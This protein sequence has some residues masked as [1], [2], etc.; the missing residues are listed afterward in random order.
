LRK[1]EERSREHDDASL[2]ELLVRIGREYAPLNRIWKDA[3]LGEFNICLYD[4]SSLEAIS[5]FGRRLA[6]CA[7][8]YSVH[9]AKLASEL[10]RIDDGLKD[11]RISQ[12]I[13]RFVRFHERLYD[14]HYHDTVDGDYAVC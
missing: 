10:R 1:L 2:I 6:L 11:D 7:K 4:P 5:S 3:C 9:Q 13:L 8:A 14:S 12:I